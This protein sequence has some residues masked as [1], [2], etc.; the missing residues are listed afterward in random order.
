MLAGAAFGAFVGGPPGALVG[1]EAGAALGIV[2]ESGIAEKACKVALTIAGWTILPDWAAAKLY[3]SKAALPPP[4][5]ENIDR[6]LSQLN[7][8]ET[9]R[10]AHDIVGSI[11]DAAKRQLLTEVTKLEHQANKSGREFQI[12]FKANIAVDD[13]GTITGLAW[14]F[15][16]PD[17]VGDEIVP[18]AF[19]SARAPLP[20]LMG[21]DS[22][23]PL[24]AW[25]DI[26]ET[27]AGLEVKGQLLLNEVAR[28]KEVAALCRA[29]ALGGL[30]IGFVTR[31]SSSRKGG[32]RTIKSL[33]LVECSIVAIPMH[34]GAKI[35]SSKSAAVAI[36]LAE[37]ISRASAALKKRR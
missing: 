26:K 35:T 23:Q 10:L 34:P 4:T 7:D 1:A 25:S 27:R 19:K 9:T 11:S 17:R 16:S 8:S 31:S 13:A 3:A 29:G 36:A 5:P 18:G 24:G 6:F 12:E 14:P 33:D 20:I 32:G 15:G 28:A 37:A 21:H 22:M 2:I 30:S